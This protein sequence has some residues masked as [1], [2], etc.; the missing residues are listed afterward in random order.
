MSTRYVPA[1]PGPLLIVNDVADLRNYAGTPNPNLY[2]LQVPL[3]AGMQMLSNLKEEQR[4]YGTYGRGSMMASHSVRSERLPSNRRRT[5]RNHSDSGTDSS[6]VD[7]NGMNSDSE[8]QQQSSHGTP[9]NNSHTRRIRKPHS[10]RNWRSMRTSM[11]DDDDDTT[12]TTSS[13]DGE[14]DSSRRKSRS[15]LHITS[16]TAMHRDSTSSSGTTSPMDSSGQGRPPLVP[17][18]KFSRQDPGTPIRSTAQ[19]FRDPDTPGG[20]LVTQLRRSSL[21]GDVPMSASDTSSSASGRQ[22]MNRIASLLRDETAPFEK[23]IAHERVTTSLFKQIPPLKFDNDAEDGGMVGVVPTFTSG[24]TSDGPN[25]SMMMNSTNNSMKSI[26]SIV[27]SIVSSTAPDSPESV[28]SAGNGTLMSL[29]DFPELAIPH[30]VRVSPIPNSQLRSPAAYI[31]NSSRLNPE[32]QF[33]SSKH[34]D[35]ITSSPAMSPVNL[36]IGHMSPINLERR[37]KRKMSMDDRF[38]PYKRHH[39]MPSSPSGNNSST[40]SLSPG[41]PMLPSP[42]LSQQLFPPLRSRSPSISM[43]MGVNSNPSSNNSSNG[44]LPMASSGQA[45]QQQQ[46]Q[47]PQPP[48]MNAMG[49]MIQGAPASLITSPPLPVSTLLSHHNH[50]PYGMGPPSMPVPIPFPATFSSM[51]DMQQQQQQQ[52]FV[53]GSP[54]MYSQSPL[55]GSVTSNGMMMVNPPA[56]PRPTPPF[57]QMLNLSGAQVEFNKMSISSSDLLLGRGDQ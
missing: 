7:N 45:P 14:S 8:Q 41:A 44:N 31:S 30:A 50:H 35:M 2:K 36:V 47:Q 46:Q 55:A 38:E 28:A 13:S 1:I 34:Q 54:R 20:F 12:S 22:S 39:R 57:G 11:A 18:R 56:S 43:M 48:V 51:V 9:R 25:A 15:M 17:P 4:L 52:Q 5:S 49:I 32:N 10:F 37:G 24:T 40:R 33:I 16:S 3:K 29:D 26:G 6:D 42:T 27:P 21:S 23:E 19:R 53:V